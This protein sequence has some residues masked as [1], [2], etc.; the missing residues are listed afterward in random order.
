M[1]HRISHRYSAGPGASLYLYQPIRYGTSLGA[2]LYLWE[3]AC[4]RRAAKQPLLLKRTV[5]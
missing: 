5:C 4:Q 2:L 1:D 3:L